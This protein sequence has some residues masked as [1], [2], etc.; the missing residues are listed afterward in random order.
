FSAPT[1]GENL[2]V[3]RPI[4]HT[5]NVATRPVIRFS[6][7]MEIVDSS[8]FEYDDFDWQVFNVGGHR[9]F[10]LNFDNT[11]LLIYY[12]LDSGGYCATA[13]SFAN[14]EI[15]EVT[16]T[17]DYARNRWSAWLDEIVLVSNQPITATS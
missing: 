3:W 8:N 10:T 7:L 2:F 9:M 4:N 11:N 16:I 6:V 12:Q 1:A 5:P 15:Y 14:G 13:E 17:M